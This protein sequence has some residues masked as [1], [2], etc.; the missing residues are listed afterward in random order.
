MVKKISI[1]IAFFL[2]S[3]TFGHSNYNVSAED[4]IPEWGFYVYMAG[5]NTLYD[6][7]TDDLNEMKMV[8]SNDDLNIIALTDK[9]GDND[10]HLYH[11]MK[12]NLI[13]TNLTEVNSTW[14][15][16]LDMGDGD[17]LRDF[18]IWASDTFP[19]KRKILVIWNHGSGWEKVAEDGT[20]FLTVPEIKHSLKQYRETTNETPFTL[21]GFDACLMGMF[22]IMYELKDHAEMVHGSEAYEP[23]EGWTYNNLLY[24]LN[25]NLNNEDLAY[26]V[27]NDYI[28]SYRNGSVYTSYSVTASVVSSNNLGK[29]WNELDNFSSEIN[30]ILPVF[31]SEIENARG[32]TQRFDQNPNYR[33]LYDLTV[34]IE[35]DIPVISV[36]EA[37]QDLRKAINETV[38]FEDHW[39]KPEKLN[40]ERANG[41][42][43]YFP[44]DGVKYGYDQLEIGSNKWFNFITN[45]ESPIQSDSNFQIVNSSSTDTGTGHNDSVLVN[46]TFEGNATV[47]TL[48]MIDDKGNIIETIVKALGSESFDNLLIQPKK[49]GNYSIELTLYGNDGYLQD[50]YYKDN[51]FVDLNLPDL[52]LDTPMLFS[53]TSEGILSHVK[54]VDIDDKFL[55]NGQISNLGT[56][57]ANNLLVRIEYDNKEKI[58]NYTELKPNEIVNWTLTDDEIF[59]NDKYSR[60]IAINVS[61]SSSDYFEIDSENNATKFSLHVHDDLPNTYDSIVR[62]LNIIELETN[63]NEYYFPWLETEIT[64]TDLTEQS[65]DLLSFNFDLPASWEINNTKLLHLEEESKVIVKI[66]PHINAI[67]GETRVPFEILD[68][69]NLT[70]G[71]GNVSITIPQYYGVSIAAQQI[72]S[73]IKILVTN[74]GNGK[75]TFK[76][77]KELEEGL[78]LYLTETYFELE[79]YETKEIN[80]QGLET[81]SN[82]DYEAIIEVESIGNDNISADLILK[83]KGNSDSNSDS[84]LNGNFFILTVGAIVF[85][86]LLT[87]KRKV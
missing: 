77:T 14:Q 9:I 29:L 11:V 81:K 3:T 19:A 56:V 35:R 2:L 31:R 76:L 15:N 60:D 68:S 61:I 86:M 43:I 74:T 65:W 79:P 78:T 37:A 21:I 75:D 16:E 48:K 1:V 41:M 51:L 39:I 27:V 70:S 87:K 32:D 40:V 20:S 34:K 58:I 42:T 25:K 24:K 52:N 22:E 71:Y 12:H 57:S 36:K 23:L 26:H 44:V 10:S 54:G 33:D 50:Y 63:A 13:E 5:D 38:M 69:N 45:Y 83:V 59:P 18:L 73:N 66:K 4:E 28:E 17:T 82:S 62:N 55:I 30:S 72:N 53:E 64:V 84:S 7:L 6:E 85:S 47:L 8:G 46:G 80:T 67:E 49:S